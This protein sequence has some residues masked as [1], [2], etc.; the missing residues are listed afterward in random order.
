MFVEKLPVPKL[1]KDE[2]APFICL[3]EYVLHSVKYE[4]K[5]QSAYFEQLI[6]GLVF[7]LYFPA[8]IKAAN[9]EV[10]KHLG[11]LTAITDAMSNENK[12]AVIQAAF[13]RLYDPRHPVRNHLETLDSI[14]EVRI[15]REALKR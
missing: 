5:L 9:K 6:D 14:E 7:E 15:I 11:D 4:K 10:L 3:A 12:L 1:K 8:E 2:Q 13:D